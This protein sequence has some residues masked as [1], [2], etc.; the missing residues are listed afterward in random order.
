MNAHLGFQ[1]AT[2]KRPRVQN[3]T[4]CQAFSCKLGF[5]S[6]FRGCNWL[7]VRRFIVRAFFRLTGASGAGRAFKRQSGEVVEGNL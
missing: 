3:I 1:V 4:R 7:T 2:L 6:R 5:N